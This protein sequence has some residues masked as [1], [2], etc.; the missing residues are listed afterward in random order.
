[1]IKFLRKTILSAVLISVSFYGVKA[2]TNCNCWQTRDTGF[3]YLPV[4]ACT[5]QC[6]DTNI[7]PYR[8][9]DGSF[10]P[11]IL[12]FQ[13]CFYGSS[14]DTVYINTNGNITIGSGKGGSSFTSFQ[15]DTFPNVTLPPM[16]AP[17]WGDVDLDGGTGSSSDVIRYKITPHYLIVQWDSVGYFPDAT[18]KLNSFQVIMSDGTTPIIPNNNN[19]EFCYRTMQWTTG[20]ATGGI[21]GFDPNNPAAA[22]PATVGANKGDGTN[23]IQ[24]GL[25]GVPGNSFLGQY[26]PYPYNGISWLNNKSF[27]FSTCSNRVPPIVTG[28]TPCDTF[29]LCTNDTVDIH[30]AFLSP[31]YTDSTYA[32]L[33]PPILSGV[34]VLS[35]TPGNTDSMVVQLIGGTGN[36]GFH[37]VNGYAYDNEIPHD[38]AF[39]SFVLEV[40]SNASGTLVASK[41]TI[42]RGDSSRLKIINSNTTNYLWSNGATTDSIEVKPT[43]TTTYSCTLTKGKCNSYT[44]SKTIVVPPVPTV[45]TSTTAATCGLCN[46]TATVNVSNGFTPYTYLWSDPGAQ[47]AATATGLCPGTYSVIVSEKGC[48]IP[49]DTSHVTITGPTVPLSAHDTILQNVN[50]RGGN[51][52]ELL[53]S[54]SGGTP[55][56]SYSWAPGGGSSDTAKNLTAGVYTVTVTDS[57]NCTATAAVTITQPASP[58]GAAITFTKNVLCNGSSTG[59]L[60]VGTSGGT[61][62]YTYSWAPNGGNGD[63]AKNLSAGSYTVTVT[64]SHGCTA[65]ATASITQP[66]TAIAAAITYTTNV[67]CN[68]NNTGALAVVASGGTP[69]YTYIWV[70][71][72]SHSDTAKNLTAGTYTIVVFDNNGCTATASATVTQPPALTATITLHKNVRCN[73]GNTGKL[74]VSTSGGIPG[75]TYSWAPSGGSSDTAKNLTAGSYTV[76]VTDNNG[77]ITTASATVTQPTALTATI[78]IDKKILC[79]GGNTGELSVN[80]SGGTPAYTYSWQP[81]GASTD[82]INNLTVGVYTV[83]VTDNHG[84]STID[85]TT[86]TQPATLTAAITFDQNVFCFGG[87]TGELAVSASGGT[88]AYTYS[89]APSGGN[90]DTAKNLTI[91]V[92]TVTV[93]DKDG[94][95]ATAT[96]TVTQPLAALGTTITYTKN[97]LCYGTSTGEIAVGTTGGTPVYTYLWMPSGGTNDTAQNLS[98]GSYTVTVTDSHGCSAT[99]TAT[100]TQ[101]ATPPTATIIYQK[102]AVCF[103]SDTGQ[104]AVAA[105]GGT[106]GYKYLWTPSGGTKDT[107][108]FLQ[109]PGAYTITVTDSNGC[110]ASTTVVIT[111]PEVG[112][113]ATVTPVENVSCY[114][115][116]NGEAA[117]A[118]SGGKAP[119]SYQWVPFGGTTDTAKNL[120]AGSYTVLLIDSNKCTTTTPD[121]VFIS[122]PPALLANISFTQNVFCRNGNTGELAVNASGGTPGYTYSW[123]PAGGSSDTAKNLTAG[124]YTVTVTDNHSCSITATA[125]ITQPPTLTATITLTKNVFCYSDNTGELA[126]HAAGGTPA[127]TYSWAPGGGSSDT[128][129]N[130]SAGSY[131]ITVTD[132]NNC[133]A[134]ATATITQPASGLGAAITYTKNVLCTGDNTGELAVNPSGGTPAYTYSWTSGGGSGDTARNLTAGS[135]TVTI[136]DNNGCSATAAAN[137]TQPASSLLATI[138]FTK[139]PLCNGYST[140]ELAVNASGGTP[141]YTY[142][143]A[144]HGGVNDTA[145]NLS[146]GSY[147]ITVTDNNGCS[148]TATATLTQPTTLSATISFTENILC[149]DVNTGELAVSVSGGTPSYTYLW[150]PGGGTSDTVKNLSAHVYAVTITDSN[151][152]LAAAT[153]PIT[154]PTALTAAMTL[155]DNVLCYGGNSGELAVSASGGTLAYTYS[156]SPNVGNSDTAK[157]LTAGAYSVTVTDS[158]GCTATAGAVITQPASPLGAVITYTKNVLC[159]GSATGEMA[160]SASGG[161]QAYTYSW[162]PA[163]GSSDTAK[164]L[165]AGMYTVTVTDSHGCTATASATITQPA[166]ALTAAITLTKDLLCNGVNTGK[167]AVNASGGTPGYT[168][169]WAPSGGNSDTAR[170]LSAGVYTATVTDNNGCTATAAATITQPTALAAPI[171]YIK[172][173]CGAGTSGGL[174]VTP[175]GGTPAYTYSW[176]PGGGSSDTAKNLTA[177]MYTVTVTDNNGCTATA[178]ATVTQAPSPLAATTSTKNVRCNDSATGMASVSASGGSPAYTYLW[179]PTGGTNDT[180]KNLVPGTYTA[181]ITDAYGCSINET[182]TVKSIGSFAINL[183]CCDTSIML[184]QEAYLFI[185]PNGRGFTYNWMPPQGLSCTSCHNPIAT[186]TVTTVYTVVVTDSLGC[187]RDT[188]ITV[189]VKIPCNNVTV[190][191]VFTPNGDGI[192]DDLKIALDTSNITSYSIIIY[193]RWGKEVYSSTNP[194]EPWNGKISNTQAL[195]PDGVYYYI[196]NLNCNDINYTKKGFVQLLGRK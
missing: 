33:L 80:P 133:I 161:T 106:P 34:S 84:C 183:A 191:N 51:N 35:N 16:V 148:A 179:T 137:V 45:G 53:A 127:Y 73:G 41:D 176:A 66:A 122:Q 77:C 27:I 150:I 97:I 99:A 46:G 49:V 18:D 101:P 110:T 43:V 6:T 163:G 112:F 109:A 71:N 25:Y 129:K 121:T 50:C 40:D 42:C 72:G 55:G 57:K 151:G 159:N 180:A 95:T 136:T 87:N 182:V 54:A 146:A 128:A 44:V 30:M 8:V 114:G 160:V 190:P 29:I 38:T 185:E 23:Y 52:G 9:D 68:G 174:A 11:V 134:T 181:I 69:A 79:N 171:T 62:A 5:S 111:R 102:N 12:P 28:I 193:D 156:W 92:Y 22:T 2:Q 168:Y 155:T 135:Y 98:A 103:A 149:N 14:N 93:T 39:F 145:K 100:L 170:N 24:F 67:L 47:T 108:Y 19:V 188:T 96:A 75:Y 21:N 152:C 74:V 118:L 64:D 154:Q 36:F 142:S 120:T 143:W 90:S 153:E 58:L 140:G 20:G 166:S 157:N 17:F 178:S 184:G 119:Y 88:T 113:T 13:F 10:G 194:E 138:P 48:N 15:I 165:T 107:A 195:V 37:T 1:M 125:T 56:Y 91:G 94:C 61:P 76:T 70:P 177:G 187:T 132:N 59:E 81:G 85:S 175:T 139:N 162:M 124:S 192:N 123:A 186:P 78:T 4:N 196:I 169:S 105:S 116:N 60:A 173:V 86:L 141:G 126:V 63:T 31:T 104:A 3:H 189:K 82:T 117:T 130:L 32:G 7:S 83:T 144:P 131:T 115:G 167:A 158:D 164:N 147:T 89:W 26:P 65:T 172:N